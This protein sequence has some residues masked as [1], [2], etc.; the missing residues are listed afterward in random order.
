[1]ENLWCAAA[2]VFQLWVLVLVFLITLPAMFG[3]SLGVT[4]VY[5]QVLVKILEVS[6]ARSVLFEVGNVLERAAVCHGKPSEDVCAFSGPHYA[7]SEGSRS[8]Q[9]CPSL[10]LQVILV[11]TQIPTYSYNNRRVRDTI[12]FKANV[13]KPDRC[14]ERVTVIVTKT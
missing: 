6:S 8:S 2:V 7:S 13:T 9:V 14:E 3:L 12:F 11:Q 10:S 4:G 1:M 5:I